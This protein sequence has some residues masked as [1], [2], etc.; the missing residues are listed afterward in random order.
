MLHIQFQQRK[1]SFDKET[2]WKAAAWRT[3]VSTGHKANVLR[4]CELAQDPMLTI[5]NSVGFSDSVT[6]E[7]VARQNLLRVWKRK[8]LQPKVT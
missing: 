2:F 4:S 5:D 6:W 3:D 8:F 7:I 1:Q